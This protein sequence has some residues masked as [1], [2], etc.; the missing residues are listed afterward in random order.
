[1]ASYLT[2]RI[3]RSFITLFIVC[4]I[5]FCLLRLMPIE[6]YFNNFDKLTE[7]QVQRQ[8]EG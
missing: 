4:T 1:M 8:L 6:G 2:K 5:V 7:S 3:L